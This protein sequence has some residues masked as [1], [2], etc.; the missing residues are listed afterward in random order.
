M[1][2]IKIDEDGLVNIKRKRNGKTIWVDAE[3]PYAGGK[4]IYCGDWCPRF[5]D[6]GN[7]EVK[8]RNHVI[9]RYRFKF[10]V[11]GRSTLGR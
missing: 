10:P 1:M 8:R 7:T 9:A 5:V 6:S 11:W 4:T 3:Y 2:E